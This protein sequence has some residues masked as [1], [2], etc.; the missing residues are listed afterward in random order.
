MAFEDVKSVLMIC[1]LLIGRIATRLPVTP[2]SKNTLLSGE[3][4]EANVVNW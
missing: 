1:E 3:S 2:F 4:L